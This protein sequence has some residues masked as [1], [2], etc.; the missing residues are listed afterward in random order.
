M[1]EKDKIRIGKVFAKLEFKE[2]PLGLTFDSEEDKEVPED[3]EKMIST[4]MFDAEILGEE[5]TIDETYADVVPDLPSVDDLLTGD[6]PGTTHEDEDTS[7][8]NLGLELQGV[9]IPVQERSKSVGV[10]QLLSIDDHPLS[11]VDE[12]L[13]LIHI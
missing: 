13:S 2:S 9:E 12:G 11:E 5:D 3:D 4:R 7:D 6:A 10:S 1:S 8:S